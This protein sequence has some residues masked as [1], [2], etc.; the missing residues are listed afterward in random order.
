M[1]ADLRFAY[2]RLCSYVNEESITQI[3]DDSF[4]ESTITSAKVM[5]KESISSSKPGRWNAS[6]SLM[7]LIT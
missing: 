5:A 2:Q 7:H 3:D 1:Q 6:E 4:L